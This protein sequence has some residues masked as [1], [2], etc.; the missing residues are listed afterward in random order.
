MRKE[1]RV[2]AKINTSMRSCPHEGE[3]EL[4]EVVSSLLL[5]NV[6]RITVALR[7]C[8]KQISESPYKALL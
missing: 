8:R 7:R 6:N 4:Q 1:R 5:F 3:G 2:R